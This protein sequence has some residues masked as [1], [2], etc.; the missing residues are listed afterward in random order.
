MKRY[1]K[2]V[3]FSLT[4]H[5]LIILSLVLSPLSSSNSKHYVLKKTKPTLNKTIIHSAAISS[6]AIEQEVAKIKAEKQAQQQAEVNRV[7]KLK[8]QAAKARRARQL[9]QRRLAKIKHQL[10][11]QKRKEAAQIRKGQ[12]QLKALKEQLAAQKAQAEKNKK[13]LEQAQKALEEKKK[14]QAEQQRQKELAKARAIAKAKALAKQQKEQEQQRVDAEV[15]KYKALIINAISQNWILP[16]G[17][18]RS[19]SCQFEIE[20]ASSGDV[21][22]V[23]L[24]RSSGDPVLDRSARTAIYQ[25]SP[26]PV[27]SMPAAFNEFKVVSLTVKPE[28]ES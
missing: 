28:E 4:L 3:I 11:R 16:S 24:L 12:K 7:N 17:V 9:E 13:E 18:D 1:S 20:L 23:R 2:A 25:A 21:K 5:L 27:P 6:Q 10:Q 8:Q 14:R 19:L 15:N 22:S 26:L